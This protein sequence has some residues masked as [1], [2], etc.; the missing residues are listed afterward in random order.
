MDNKKLSSLP[1]MKHFQ[2]SEIGKSIDSFR[3]G[4]KGLFNIFKLVVLCGLGYLAWVYVLPP[5]FV[6]LGELFAIVATLVGVAICI[7]LIPTFLRWLRAFT[8][9]VHE[10]AIKYDPFGPLYE[11]RKEMDENKRTFQIAKGKIYQLKN[12]MEI[13][14]DE[15]EKNAKTLETVIIKIKGKVDKLKTYMDDLVKNGGASAKGTD[16]YVNAQS[17]FLKLGASAERKG[18]ELNQQKTF[19]QKYGTRG[20]VMKKMG[21]KLTMIETSMD[22]KI[23]DYDATIEILKN[24]YA[25]AQKAKEATSAARD[26]M[27]FENGWEVEFAMDVVVSTIAQDNAITAGNIK[28]IDTAMI[29]YAMD[30]D[31][32]YDNLNKLAEDIQAGNDPIPEAKKYTN[33]EYKFT[34]DDKKSTGFGEDMF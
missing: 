28:D 7:A 2:E 27:V 20:A 12:D 25:Y 18:H 24:D 19:V 22:I 4:E 23:L 11:R 10:R 3:K 5:V 17:E 26:A 9:K 6:A 15:S 31:D 32:L 8:R 29:T 34:Q 14:A 1:I 33:P 30:S 16:D 21:H 13:S